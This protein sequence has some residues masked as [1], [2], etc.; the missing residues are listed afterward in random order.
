LSYRVHR[1]EKAWL[2][3][4]LFLLS[5]VVMA[6]AAYAQATSIDATTERVQIQQAFFITDR[7]ARRYHHIYFWFYGFKIQG[8]WVKVYGW[9]YD[10]YKNFSYTFYYSE[11]FPSADAIVTVSITSEFV[12]IYWYYYTVCDAHECEVTINM[13]ITGLRDH[14]RGP[15]DP[16]SY[17]VSYVRDY[18]DPTISDYVYNGFGN[19]TGFVFAFPPPQSKLREGRVHHGMTKHK[20]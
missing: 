3:P 5:L 18:F 10:A 6:P 9:Y 4:R 15:F 7:P 17:S 16:V 2:L 1:D 14:A 11:R 8:E 13:Q 20:I 19:L 12:I